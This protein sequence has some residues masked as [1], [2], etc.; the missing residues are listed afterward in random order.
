MVVM[1]AGLDGCYAGKIV[2]RSCP[3]DCLREDM[4]QPPSANLKFDC[5]LPAIVIVAA[6]P[7]M[8]RVVRT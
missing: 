7:I 6:E 4:S 5:L 2:I 3:C 1:G 8:E